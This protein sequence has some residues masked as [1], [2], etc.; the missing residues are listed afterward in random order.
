MQAIA[1]R[2]QLSF[3]SSRRSAVT[4]VITMPYTIHMHHPEASERRSLQPDELQQ[5]LS[6]LKVGKAAGPDNIAPDLL[7]HLST[8]G[9]SVLLTILNS[10][11][12]SIRCPQFMRSAYL[13]PFLKME[14]TQQTWEVTTP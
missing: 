12:L 6:Q 9:S 8:I 10:S 5:A 4:K 7:R 13:V 11:W 1:Q 2:P 3:K 14:M